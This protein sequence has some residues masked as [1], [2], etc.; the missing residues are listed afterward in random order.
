MNTEQNTA[1]TVNGEDISVEEAVALIRR[2]VGADPT[3]KTPWYSPIVNE[4]LIR[5]IAKREGISDITDPELEGE[6][7]AIRVALGL[8]SAKDF[9][10]WLV[11]NGISLEDLEYGAETNLLADKWARKLV[12]SKVEAYFSENI[13]DFDQVDL[14][15][16][17][18]P[19]QDV[20]HEL[21]EQLDQG[22]ADFAAL[23]RAYSIDDSGE[24]MGQLGFVQR[25]ALSKEIEAAVFDAKEN[26]TVGPLASD[27][28]YHIFYVHSFKPAELDESLQRQIRTILMQPMLD[29]E[30]TR[31]QVKV[32]VPTGGQFSA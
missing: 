32:L 5:K 4:L 2:H 22:E 28:G 1:L 26:S 17:V 25:A 18:V 19:D 3:N 15:Q 29:T 8:Y 16:V 9:Q 20:A 24:R 27:Q 31:L 10:A 14:S 12:G 30:R 23:A 21:K 7:N 13:S 6:I 11:M